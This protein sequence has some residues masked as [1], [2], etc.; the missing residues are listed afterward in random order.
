MMKMT[1]PTDPAARMRSLPTDDGLCRHT[2]KPHAAPPRN[3]ALG[4]PACE[5][6]LVYTPPSVR[7]RT[8]APGAWGGVRMI[9]RIITTAISC[10]VAASLLLGGGCG[11]APKKAGDAAPAPDGGGEKKDAP[12]ATPAAAP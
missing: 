3:P 9:R 4:S 6:W 11:G 2:R 12:P 5:R 8:A 1:A 7:G 10:V